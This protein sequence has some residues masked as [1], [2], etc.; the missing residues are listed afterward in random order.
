MD[1]NIIYSH[2]YNAHYLMRLKWKL[3]QELKFVI[4]KIL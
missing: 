3:A 4:K 2:Y 1:K